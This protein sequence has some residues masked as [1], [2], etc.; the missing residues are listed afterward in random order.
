MRYTIVAVILAGHLVLGVGTPVAETLGSGIP[1]YYEQN[2]FNLT[3]PTALIAPSGGFTN[4]AVYGMLWDPAAQFGWTNSGG[5]VDTAEEWGFFTGVKRLGFGMIERKFATEDGDGIARV[6]DIRIGLVE[7]HW[8]TRVAVAYGWSN[9]DG[10]DLGRKNIMQVG[11]VHRVGNLMTFGAV[12]SFA[13]DG[14]T[15]TGF[16]DVS[17][18]PLGNWLTVFAD[19]E[20]PKGIDAADAPWSAG[21]VFE[22]IP[23]VNISGRYYY[24][25]RYL[26]SVGF[27]F[28][29]LWL[30]G[31]PGYDQDY[32]RTSTQYDVRVGGD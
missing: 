17:M 13:I 22:A 7:H 23:G 9:D 27:K 21:A 28:Y 31:A 15:Q 6:Q 18:R 10:K 20:L 4:P 16:F 19:A 3:S 1:S 32:N 5:R 12:G 11:L 24:D 30:T 14:T 29:G 8:R 2:P 25:N 26:L